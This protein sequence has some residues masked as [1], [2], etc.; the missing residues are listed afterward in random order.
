[1]GAQAFHG[2]C[3]SRNGP[4]HWPWIATVPALPVLQARASSRHGDRYSSKVHVNTPLAVVAEPRRVPPTLLT[5]V[6]WMQHDS[7][8]AGATQRTPASMWSEIAF[9]TTA[10]PV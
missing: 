9:P 4:R 2:H 3:L 5:E 1:M 6:G 10:E 7:T 8:S